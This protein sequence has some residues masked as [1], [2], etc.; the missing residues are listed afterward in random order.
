MCQ[1]H[2]PSLDFFFQS[3]ENVNTYSQL[4]G[5]NRHRLW[6]DLAHGQGLVTPDILNTWV[7]INV[8]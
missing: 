8:K 5:H 1:K 2:Y 3:F 4:K 6:A 7:Y